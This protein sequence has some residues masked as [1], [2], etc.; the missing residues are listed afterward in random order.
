VNLSLH[1]NKYL[2]LCQ[3]RFSSTDGR[4]RSFGAGGD[5]YVPGEGVG[6]V[7]LKT[8]ADAE[9]DGDEIR[10]VIKATGCN[11]GG[12]TN[13]YSVPNPNAQANL[14]ADVM[15]KSGVDPRSISFVEAHG[16][17]T[18][19]GDPIEIA[20]LT[21]AFEEFT[22]ERQFCSIG[23]AK[24]N[25][26]HLEAAAGVA[27]VAKVLLQLKHRQLAPS[28][29]SATINPNI[30][31]EQTPFLLQRDLATW[32][33]PVFD[34]VEQPLRAAISS[35]GA[36][37]SNANL[38]MEEYSTPVPAP[39]GGD[40]SE[41]IVLSAANGGRLRKRASQLMAFLESSAEWHLADVAYT[42]QVGR[43]PMASRLAFVAASGEE[44]LGGLAAF[45]NGG[46]AR[47]HVGHAGD[48]RDETGVRQ[49]SPQGIEGPGADVQDEAAS[50]WVLG[51]PVEWRLVRGAGA[52]ARRISLPT[53]PFEGERY[54]VP[55][56]PAG[57]LNGQAAG[58]EPAADIGAMSEKDLDAR[59][60]ELLGNA[61]EAT[62][63]SISHW[64]PVTRRGFSPTRASRNGDAPGVAAGVDR[65]KPAEDLSLR[66]GPDHGIGNIEP[67]LN[68]LLP[69]RVHG[70]S[71]DE[72]IAAIEG[73]IG[74]LLKL[75]PGAGDRKKP[76]TDFGLDSIGAVKLANELYNK[77]GVPVTPALFAEHPSID[78]LAR[79][80]A[81]DQRTGGAS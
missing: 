78:A 1:P 54:W 46:S 28:L 38:I 21:R 69:G 67:K 53:Y 2:Q 43:R 75:R 14:I 45:L 52:R 37:G 55:G 77:L 25:I 9:R 62:L 57:E 8:L 23:S 16:T 12:K 7:L 64:L 51:E 3:L 60:L 44:L 49:A 41:I 27:A 15:D 32:K 50:A 6:A 4:C 81:A 26:G 59:L 31:F 71:E 80:L 76:F 70:A 48:R 63:D 33:R 17:G 39:K 56:V 61:D 73:A 19:L 36:G 18:A 58:A 34:G 29:H 22:D 20:G 35:F 74:R 66:R 13:G 24:S 30:R 47:V 72:V 65:A 40:T 10:A 42:L 79:Y 5:G 11:H 68:V